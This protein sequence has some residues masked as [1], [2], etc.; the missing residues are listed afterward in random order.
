METAP[1]AGKFQQP[2]TRSPDLERRKSCNCHTD[3]NRGKT[4]R[5]SGGE[6]ASEKIPHTEDANEENA[7]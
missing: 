4:G 5:N 6:T 1:M 7:D 2:S 3:K